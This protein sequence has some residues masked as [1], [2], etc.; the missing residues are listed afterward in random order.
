MLAGML[1]CLNAG[2]YLGKRKLATDPEGALEA[3]AFSTEQSFDFM[4][5]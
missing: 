5:C 3:S 2:R 4:A 1:A